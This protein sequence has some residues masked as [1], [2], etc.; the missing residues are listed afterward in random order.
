ME[1]F[2]QLKLFDNDWTEV[3]TLNPRLEFAK[4]KFS[5][6][7]NGG[8]SDMQ[9]CFD[10]S[11]D[12]TTVSW[13][14]F[15]KV[16]EFDENNKSWKTIYTWYIERITRVIN[17]R[18]AY[19]CID[20]IGLFALMNRV[21]YRDTW[22]RTH[23][24]TDDPGTIV[25]DIVSAFNTAY[26]WSWLSVGS[27]DSYWSSVSIAFDNRSCADAIKDVYETVQN[28][29]YF[30]IAGD[31]QVYLKQN[32]TTATYKLKM[33]PEIESM[34][35]IEKYDIVNTVWVEY[36]WWSEET[37]TDATSVTN[38][39]LSEE[40]LT[41]SDIQNSATADQLAEQYV[42]A[43]KDMIPEIVIDVVNRTDMEDM[44]PGQTVS[45]YNSSYTV[46]NKQINKVVYN[47][48]KVTLHLGSFESFGSVFL[49]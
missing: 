3:K 44:R 16:I 27:I 2:Y 45:V 40:K 9:F 30:Y 34:E 32:P 38:Y 20:C 36:S 5:A 33:W 29:W 8:V 35:I 43:H 6:I 23:T 39:W 48:K 18:G 4:K 17:E 11:I 28:R 24:Q 26:G 15:I 19:V 14:Q 37:D 25:T 7:I 12:D 47:E 22:N 21:I 42:D 31:G 46:T 1:K 49:S 41:R 13:W 10:V